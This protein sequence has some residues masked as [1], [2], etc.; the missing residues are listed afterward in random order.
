MMKLIERAR[1]AVSSSDEPVGGQQDDPY[2]QEMLNVAEQAAKHRDR[3]LQ[4]QGGAH[5]SEIMRQQEANKIGRE[6]MGAAGLLLRLT[7]RKPAF[8]FLTASFSLEPSE[9]GTAPLISIVFSAGTAE[10]LRAQ[11]SGRDLREAGVLCGSLNKGQV[12]ALEKIE[13]SHPESPDVEIDPY[14]SVDTLNRFLEVCRSWL[15]AHVKPRVLMSHR[16]EILAY[17]APVEVPDEE[18]E[19]AA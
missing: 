5:Q 14:E 18:Q 4:S 1:S 8:S 13:V 10:H 16:E 11:V 7:G 12:L 9:Q 3:H 19:A 2:F 17:L 15:A 6:V